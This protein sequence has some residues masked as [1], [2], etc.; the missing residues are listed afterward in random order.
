MTKYFVLSL[1]A[2]ISTQ[3]ECL[4]LCINWLGVYFERGYVNQVSAWMIEIVFPLDCIIN[5]I[6]L[7]LLFEI[8]KDIYNKWCSGCHSCMGLC[9]RRNTERKIR[10]TMSSMK[11]VMNNSNT[12]TLNSNSSITFSYIDSRSFATD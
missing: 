11:L 4:L 9:F 8:N 12:P 5:T 3:I 10:K 7:F 1:I 2:T 6:C